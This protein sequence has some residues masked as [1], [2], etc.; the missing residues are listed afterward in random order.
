MSRSRAA[1]APRDNHEHD[2]AQAMMLDELEAL[3]ELGRPPT[4]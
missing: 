1:R 4:R 2:D 3:E